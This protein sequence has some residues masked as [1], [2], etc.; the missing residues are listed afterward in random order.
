MLFAPRNNATVY[1]QIAWDR[2]SSRSLRER[3]NSGLTWV[4]K[5][6]ELEMHGA[7]KMPQ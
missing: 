4:G 1:L 6:E 2:K 3:T 7:D 5:P